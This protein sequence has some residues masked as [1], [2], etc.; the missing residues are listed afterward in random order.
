V[1]GFPI[2]SVV[3]PSFNQAEFLRRT[4]ESVL[5]QDYP[6]VEYL[7]M[8]GGSSDGSPQIIREYD[9]RLAYWI[10]EPDGG[11]SD[12]INRG[13]QRSRGDIL[14]WLNS[15][16]TYEPGAISAAVEA[17]RRDAALDLVAGDCRVI[18]HRDRPVQD[19]PSGELNGMSLLS[20][21]SLPQPGLFF[22][23][24]AVEAAGWL[25]ASRRYE[26]DWELLLKLWLGGRHSYHLKRVVAN[27]RVWSASKT[28]SGTVGASLSG[29]E[30]FAEE[31]LVV[32]DELVKRPPTEVHPDL[33]ATLTDAWRGNLLEL[34]LLSQ[35]GPRP[36]RAADY[37]AQY[38]AKGPAPNG[39]LPHA[40]ALTAH[41]AYFD[42]DID[43][44]IARFLDELSARLPDPPDERQR[45]T[46]E[47][48]LGAEACRVRG[49]HQV[50]LRDY[51]RASGCFFAAIRRN[52]ALLLE[53][54]TASPALKSMLLWMMGRGRRRS[55]DD[56]PQTIG[57]RQ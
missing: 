27:F 47:R 15:D 43:R 52:P 48:E 40:A 34:A 35:L 29:G 20:G 5:G 45:R 37:F 17:F 57:H 3:T 9:R 18:D 50:H 14:A 42:G 24:A 12:A 32:L 7:I 28:A 54:R 46:W 1:A 53:R 55:L 56:R 6:H 30:R 25:D 26:F 10:S 44:A 11:Q 8:D 49:W 39:A 4:I 22:R 51:K 36:E 38:A 23:R 33:Q 31:R 2:V 41:L 13:W 21:N 19:L 16:D